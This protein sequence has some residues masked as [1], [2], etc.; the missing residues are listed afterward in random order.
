MQDANVAPAFAERGIETVLY[1]QPVPS[2]RHFGRFYQQSK[3]VASKLRD[4]GADIV[5]FAEINGAITCGFAAMLAGAKRV[6][7]VRNVYPTRPLWKDW[8]ILRT[9]QAFIFV[10]KQARDFSPIP[11]GKRKARVIY[12]AVTVPAP[13]ADQQTSAQLRSDLGIPEGAPV[14]GMV[15]RVN[16]QKDY[17]T[18]AHA[19]A[20]VLQQRPDTRFLIVGDKSMVDV[21]RA[22][23]EEVSALLHKL[24]IASSFVF[25]GHR[26]DVKPLIGIMDFCV[27]STHREGFP[28]SI[29]ETMAQRKPVIATEVGGIPEIIRPGEN[30]YLVPHGDAQALADR[31]LSLIN[32]PAL[33][34]R[35]GQQAAALV[36]RDYSPEHFAEEIIAVYRSL[37]PRGVQTAS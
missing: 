35:M 6:S 10:S 11:G 22:H 12:D 21:N 1:Q 9:V 18:L 3:L 19:A 34:Q 25:A 28:L 29:L 7:H 15:A 13:N 5:H 20:L 4:A 16:P 26:E 33:A 30:G 32:E 31:I 23:Y 27:L 36:Q 8:L 24:G 2:L 17:P 14:V 37:V